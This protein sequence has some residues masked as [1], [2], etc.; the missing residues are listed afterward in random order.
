MVNET[1]LLSYWEHFKK[2][3]DI[4]LIYPP[5]HR[6]RIELQEEIDKMLL[7]INNGK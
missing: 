3:K 6:I 7:K 4:A 5:G 2:A 1:L